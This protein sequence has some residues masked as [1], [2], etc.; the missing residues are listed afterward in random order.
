MALTHKQRRFVQEYLRSETATEAALRAGYASSSAAVMASRMMDDPDILAAIEEGQQ[1]RL[2][3]VEVDAD[4]LLDRLHEE[5]EAD[6]LDLYDETGD[7]LPVEEW[8]P[9]WRKGLVAGIEIEALFDGRGEDRKRI[10]SIKKIKLSDRVRRL[11]AIGRHVS[12]AAF[13]DTLEIKGLDGLADRLARLSRAQ[14]AG[15]AE[16]P[17]PPAEA[18]LTPEPTPGPKI[19]PKPEQAPA[20]SPAVVADWEGPKHPAPYQPILP[21][22]E[23]Q[24]F[25]DTEYE[26]DQDG[27]L[28]ARRNT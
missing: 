13:R 7:L 4:Y 2:D 27:F 28:S 18:L 6:L 10:G 1:K 16:R 25:A 15:E 12:V 17:A 26:N 21:Y 23:R 11:E 14:A 24:G 20:P 3:R 22:P 5:V 8:P 9:I 19:T